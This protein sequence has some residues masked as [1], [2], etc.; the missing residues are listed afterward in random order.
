M[1]AASGL[2]LGRHVLISSSLA[3][4]VAGIALAICLVLFKICCCGGHEC[5]SGAGAIER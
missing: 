2:G 3:V 1:H 4:E 5:G